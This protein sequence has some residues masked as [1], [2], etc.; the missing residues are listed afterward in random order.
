MCVIHKKPKGKSV[1]HPG[2]I[3]YSEIHTRYVE[4]SNDLIG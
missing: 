1:E 4:I 2:D 3:L